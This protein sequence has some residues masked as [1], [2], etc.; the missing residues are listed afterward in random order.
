MGDL[1]AVFSR[2]AQSGVETRVTVSSEEVKCDSR[3]GI[4]T[5]LVIT[6]L[7]DGLVHRQTEGAAERENERG[8]HGHEKGA[9]RGRRRC[10][11]TK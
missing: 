10:W 2:H 4:G 7:S 3:V 11:V 8:E 1:I 9:W 5:T 6:D